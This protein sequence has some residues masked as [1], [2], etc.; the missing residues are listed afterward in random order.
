MAAPVCARESRASSRQ[1]DAYPLG[2]IGILGVAHAISI[3]LQTHRLQGDHPG[4]AVQ[5]R[6]NTI[7]NVSFVLDSQNRVLRVERVKRQI[8]PQ[9]IYFE[10]F[11]T[12]MDNLSPFLS[13]L[14]LCIFF[15]WYEH[16]R[17]NPYVI[18]FKICMGALLSRVHLVHL[19]GFVAQSHF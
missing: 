1:V 3:R 8:I 7:D 2:V 11:R 13:L 4:C 18:M 5:A 10:N 16:Q 15:F 12:L 19:L 6:V 17:K 14:S 9:A